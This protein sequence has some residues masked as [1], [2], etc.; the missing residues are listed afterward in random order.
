MTLDEY[1]AG[2]DSSRRIYDAVAEAVGQL[3]DVEARA[4]KTQVAFRH[5]VGFAYAW[6]PERHLGRPAAPLVLSVALRRRDTSPRW[7]EVVEPASGRFMHHLELRRPDEVDG[8]VAGWLREAWDLS[9]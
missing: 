7:K 1:F 6:V 8:E 5:R 2:L 4:T 9:G 3:G